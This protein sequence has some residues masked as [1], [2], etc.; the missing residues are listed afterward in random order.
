MI[1]TTVEEL[2]RAEIY[3]VIK[4]TLEEEYIKLQVNKITFSEDCIDNILKVDCKFFESGGSKIKTLKSTGVGLVDA[5]FVGLLKHYGKRFPSINSVSFEGFEVLP[6]FS[7]KIKS[8]S[9]SPV[10][11]AIKLSNSCNSIM[12]FRTSGR[13]FVSA[14]ALGVFRAIEFYI[15]AEKA[16]KKL[17]TLIKEAQSRNRFDISQEYV[18]KISTIVKVTSYE[19]V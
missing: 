4:S 17:K 10:D 14:C 13:S 8:G 2:K 5:L 6:D 16:F 19:Q 15:N 3:K 7:R 18:S 11:V 9:D 12:T 1:R